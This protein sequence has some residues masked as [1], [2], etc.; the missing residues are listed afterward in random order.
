[1][2]QKIQI[3]DREMGWQDHHRTPMMGDIS[4]QY[5]VIGTFLKMTNIL[6][7]NKGSQSSIW[8]DTLFMEPED[9]SISF[10]AKFF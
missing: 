2:S 1:M 5:L 8:V 9:W 4:F 6:S 10:K 3:K 7:F